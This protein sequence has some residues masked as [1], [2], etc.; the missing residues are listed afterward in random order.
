MLKR[1]RISLTGPLLAP[2]R[3]ST[4]NFNVNIEISK[5]VSDSLSD[6]LFNSIKWYSCIGERRED[7]C[8]KHEINATT[9]YSIH[10]N[11]DDH[12]F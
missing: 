8:L 9:S 2:R 5:E 6:L 7:L 3:M 1:Q 10:W 12:H 11:D 4:E